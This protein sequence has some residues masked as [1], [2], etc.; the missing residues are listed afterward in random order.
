M[1]YCYHKDFENAFLPVNVCALLKMCNFERLKNCM[2]RSYSIV[3]QENTTE[4]ISVIND[5]DV[6]VKLQTGVREMG[7]PSS[8][9][10]LA[11]Q[12]LTGWH[13]EA[14]CASGH[15]HRR[16]TPKI[17]VLEVTEGG[18]E[19]LLKFSSRDEKIFH[20]KQI[21]VELLGLWL[22]NVSTFP[23]MRTQLFQII[24]MASIVI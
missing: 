19:H 18:L 24:L 14:S 20:I 12:S 15:A 22:W 21:Y 2:T 9:Q 3:W 17:W 13:S 5:G 7:P 10:I 4:M 16:G 1:L 11:P 23:R 8:H 6:S